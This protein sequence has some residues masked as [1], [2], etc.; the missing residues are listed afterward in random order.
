MIKKILHTIALILFNVIVVAFVFTNVFG[1]VSKNGD[2]GN[3]LNSV[4]GA[5]EAGYTINTGKPAVYYKSWYQ[6]V[7]DV[8]AGNAQIAGAAEAE[9]TVLLKNEI[10]DE[11]S[12]ERALPLNKEEDKISLFGVNAYNPVYSLNGAGAIGLNNDRK[13]FFK[14]E[15]AAEGFDVNTELADWY[16]ANQSYWRDEPTA[17]FHNAKMNGASWDE[18]NTSAKT[19]DGYKTAVYVVSRVGNEGNELPPYQNGAGGTE[20]LTDG[21]YLKLTAKEQS[22]L[23]GLKDEKDKGTFDRIIVLINVASP[24]QEDFINNA[25]YGI[26]A[27]LWIGLPGSH[28]IPAVADILSGATAPSGKLPMAWYSA[29]EN[30]PTWNYYSTSNNVL[31]QEGIYVGYK[32]AETRYEDYVMSSPGAG[33][34]IYK[35]EVNYPFGY[36]LSYTTFSKEIVSLEVDRDPAKNY[37]HKGDLK[38]AEERRR[39]GDDYI[40]KVKVTNTGAVAGKEVVQVYLQQPYT[41][42]NKENGVEKPSAELIGF[43]KTRKLESGDEETVEIKIDANKYFAAY[44]IT[45][46]T[47]VLDEGKYYLTVA[48]DSHDAVNNILAAKGIDNDKIV[49]H[50]GAAADGRASFVKTVDVSASRSESYEYWTQGGAEVTNLFD[51]ADPNKCDPDGNEITFMS[52]NNWEGTVSDSVQSVTITSKRDEGRQFS[53]DSAFENNGKTHYPYYEDKYPTYGRELEQPLMLADMIGVEYDPARGASE[54]D[55]QKWNDF[56]DQLTWEEMCTLTGKGRRMTEE[57][58]SIQKPQ[59]NDLNASNGINWK[60]NPKLND[61]NSNDKIGFAYRFDSANRNLYP[62]GYPCE[63][64]VAATFN[65][66]IAHAVGNAIGEDGLW[67]GA[68][69]L[70]GFGLNLQRNPYHGRTGEY[71]GDDPYLTGVMAGWSSYGAWEKGLYV[72]NKH[73][74]LNDQEKTR[75]SYSTWITEQALRQTH[76]RPFEIAIEI[77][78][79]MCVMTAFSRIGTYWSGVDY[80]LM[81]RWLRGEAGMRGFAVTDWYKS[82]GMNMLNGLLAGQDLPDGDAYNTLVNYGPDNGG[83]GF[84]A[85]AMR[86]S[87]QRILYTVANSN[88]MNFYGEGTVFVPGTDPEWWS[89]RDNL[90]VAVDVLFIVSCVFLAFTSG[91]VILDKVMKKRKGN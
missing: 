2:V 81:T 82:S 40:L 12:N 33:E 69:G 5:G 24:I 51:H 67:A 73:F 20:G 68:S 35:D 41:Q 32:Y 57:I 39:N 48:E 50:E 45:Q 58:Q 15:L 64:I 29:R 42:T 37:D 25:A 88:A 70:Y 91:W 21:D 59:T 47:Y 62:V 19:K 49:D 4:F 16:N 27:A 8:I 72:Y 55:I 11:E 83:Y 74:V 26:D 38:P 6:S 84:F 10:I 60:F 90:V 1:I 63:G 31:Y 44:D 13:Q 79:A 23:K 66:E 56:L 77:G 89:V 87:A 22:M 85:Q 17:K 53:N 52:R 61:G 36:G 65:T 30:N 28:G 34:Y 75:S 9:G 71:Y 78:D 43:A 76:L 54:E 14:D 18:V 86:V 46:N 7:E 3:A 80:N